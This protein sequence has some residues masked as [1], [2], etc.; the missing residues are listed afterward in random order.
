ML[1]SSYYYPPSPPLSMTKTTNMDSTSYL[2]LEKVVQVYGNQPELLELILSSKVEED[3]RRAE[4]AKLRRKEIDYM[5]QHKKT[6]SLPPISPNKTVS[7]PRLTPTASTTNSTYKRK[8]SNSIEMLLSSPSDLK[9]P[10]L[11]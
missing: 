9:L 11:K 3:R 4:E 6:T 10:T 7:L 5:L 2:N 8:N 1:T